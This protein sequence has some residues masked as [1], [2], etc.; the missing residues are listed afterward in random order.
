MQNRTYN[1]RMRI[2]DIIESDE[3]PTTLTE[4]AWRAKISRRCLYYY[5]ESNPEFAYIVRRSV[6]IARLS[7]FAKAFQRRTQNLRT[8]TEYI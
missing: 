8:E 2:Y 4:L 1:N 6:Q 5:M 3:C 7:A